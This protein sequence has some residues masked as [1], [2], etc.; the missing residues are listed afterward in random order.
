MLTDGSTLPHKYILVIHH[1]GILVQGIIG[2]TNH[3]H[4]KSGIQKAGPLWFSFRTLVVRWA[5]SCTPESRS[6]KVPSCFAYSE[7]FWHISNSQYLKLNKIADTNTYTTLL[8]CEREDIDF[9]AI[10]V[11]IA[12]IR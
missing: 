5:H 2:T 3:S 12:R 10:A 11:W 8:D 6:P 1:E 7:S 4:E 9:L